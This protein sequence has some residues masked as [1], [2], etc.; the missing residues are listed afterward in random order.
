[1]PPAR[2]RPGR[3]VA[4][5]GRT[6]G[7]CDSIATPDGASGRRRRLR[8][9]RL[10]PGLSGPRGG[11][12]PAGFAPVLSGLSTKELMYEAAV[13]AYDD[14]GVDP[15]TDVDSFVCCSEALLEGTPIFDECVP[16]QLGAVQ[17][18]VQTVS[19]DGLMGLA[20]GVM[21][22]RSGVANVVAVEAHSK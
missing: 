21:L 19:S 7:G 6:R 2:S 4:A 18:P 8:P 1:V 12:G 9:P 22:I 3:A 15:R 20:T 14:A 5:P 13:R 10:R 16:G 17:R 11:S